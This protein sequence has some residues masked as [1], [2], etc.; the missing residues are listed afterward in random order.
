M[1]ADGET[2]GGCN[3]TSTTCSD[4]SENC[5]QDGSSYLFGTCVYINGSVPDGFG[6]GV[7]RTGEWGVVYIVQARSYG[8][9]MYI[10]ARSVNNFT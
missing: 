4:A 1:F 10:Q 8:I 5:N 9:Y 7:C 2:L 3:G 6:D